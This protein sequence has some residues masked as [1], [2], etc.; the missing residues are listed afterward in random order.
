VQV[1]GVAAH[2]VTI[3]DAKQQAGRDRRAER[4]QALHAAAAASG[5]EEGQAAGEAACCCERCCL[6]RLDALVV[7]QAGG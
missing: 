2:G 5:Q 7:L 4:Q 6:A 1:G 3:G